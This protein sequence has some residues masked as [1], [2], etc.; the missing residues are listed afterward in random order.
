MAFRCMQPFHFRVF[1]LCWYD[2]T[3]GR[4]SELCGFLCWFYFWH[5][6]HYACWMSFLNWWFMHD[7]ACMICFRLHSSFWMLTLDCFVGNFKCF[8]F[9]FSR[10]SHSLIYWL[11]LSESVVWTSTPTSTHCTCTHYTHTLY[12]AFRYMQPFQVS[13]CTLCWHDLTE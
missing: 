9:I 12:M 13:V 8:G 10:D 2:F 7:A 1:T 5:L 4:S 3:E 11:P 6:L